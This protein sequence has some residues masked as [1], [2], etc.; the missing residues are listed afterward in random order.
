VCAPNIHRNE[1]AQE[2]PFGAAS[3]KTAG[4]ARTIKYMTRF[5]QVATAP[6]QRCHKGWDSARFGLLLPMIGQPLFW[7]R[8]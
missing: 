2:A 6:Q 8:A 1:V 7:L 5:A 4:V 3:Q